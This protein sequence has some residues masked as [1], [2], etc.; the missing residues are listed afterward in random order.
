MA[1]KIRGKLRNAGF[2]AGHA[3]FP[4]G[5]SFERN[6]CS[7]LA[8]WPPEASG[9][10]HPGERCAAAE[11]SVLAGEKVRF[12]GGVGEFLSIAVGQLSG[13]VSGRKL[14]PADNPRIRTTWRPAAG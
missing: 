5:A 14:A 4:A 11:I 8:E 13:R 2:F 1:G 3:N 7:F 10:Q 12:T 9:S 6:W